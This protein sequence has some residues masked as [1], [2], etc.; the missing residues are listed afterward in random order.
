VKEEN[1]GLERM[2]GK[3]GKVGEIGEDRSPLGGVG[4]QSKQRQG[5]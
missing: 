5:P 1:G 3:H 4:E 2:G